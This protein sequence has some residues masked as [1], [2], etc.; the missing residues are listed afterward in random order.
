DPD[1]QIKYTRRVEQSPKRE[2]VLEMEMTWADRLRETG[3]LE[4]LEA[5]R[6]EGVAL[7]RQEGVALGRQEGVA[8]GRQEGVALGRQEGVESG[9]RE[10]VTVA[11]RLLLEL[12]A[13][14][15]GSAASRI[16]RRFETLDDLAEIAEWS[17]KVLRARSLS[18]LGLPD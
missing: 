3:R 6:Q 7:G 2:E 17:E 16:S 12:V 9:R 15:F 10:G 13:S 8:L 14:R 5:G 1:Q 11:R 4:G 18:D